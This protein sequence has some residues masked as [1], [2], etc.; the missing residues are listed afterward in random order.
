MEYEEL[1]NKYGSYSSWA[2][3]NEKDQ[4]DTTVIDKNLKELNTNYV[5]IGLNISRLLDTPAW[6]NFHGGKHDRKLMFACNNSKLKG[7]Y[8]TD[9]FK[10]IPTT[11][12]VEFATE[13]KKCITNDSKF[14]DKQIADFNKEMEDIKIGKDTVLVVLGNDARKYFKKYFQNEYENKL[15]YYCHYSYYRIP[16]EEWVNGLWKKLGIKKIEEWRKSKLG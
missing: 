16:D 10:G 11:T 5:F 13:L 9:I 1:K 6:S 4:K 7:S 8:L 12:A 2:I 15:V 14:I 3:W